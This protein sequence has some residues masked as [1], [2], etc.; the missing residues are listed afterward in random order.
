MWPGSD[1]ETYRC[2]FIPYVYIH[3]E[4]IVSHYLVL[5]SGVDWATGALV[6]WSLTD[7]PDSAPQGTTYSEE[8][9]WE[10]SWRHLESVDK[11]AMC[12]SPPWRQ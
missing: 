6:I 7:T 2:A 12:N 10:V 1:I 5:V 11:L 4:F 9:S 8:V 3:S